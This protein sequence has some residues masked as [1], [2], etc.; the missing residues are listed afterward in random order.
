MNNTD[1]VNNNVSN[2]VAK[3]SKN[4][5]PST[6]MKLDKKKK[7]MFIIAF[8]LIIVVI[9][10]VLFIS[11]QKAGIGGQPTNEDG[12]LVVETGTTWGD[13]YANFIQKEMVDISSYDVSLVDL[14][15]NG[16][17]EVLIEY[18]DA[19]DKQDFKILY[20]NDGKVFASKVFRLYSI[21]LLYSLETKETNWYIYISANEKYG[22]YT[23]LAKIINGT[24][25]DS[26]IKTGTD[27]EIE[28][29]ELA[30][31]ESDYKPVFYR[32][33]TD[34]FVE[35]MKNIVSRYNGYDEQVKKAIE[36]IEKE[37]KDK[38]YTPIQGEVEEV[39]YILVAGRK[40][41]FGVYSGSDDNGVVYTI[42]LNSR[43]SLIVNGSY[44]TYKIVDKD[45]VLGDETT[46][47]VTGND[48][49]K[50]QGVNYNFVKDETNNEIPQELPDED[51]SNEILPEI[52]DDDS[53]NLEEQ[54]S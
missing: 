21:H 16:T 20:L 43:N 33:S 38:E 47:N 18:V 6:K 54:V 2:D 37:N 46:I 8:I 22:A 5:M 26:D 11:S 40:L 10:V 51:A 28:K 30:Y 31:D 45:L 24:A 15:F 50:Y 25:F 29:F 52:S 36:E 19:E 13:L 27:S 12:T 23:S 41:N 35:D 9:F 34:S 53:N 42:M 3:T 7:Q 4:S 44:V 17:P 1:N 48:T 39:N 14:D 49:F 32:V